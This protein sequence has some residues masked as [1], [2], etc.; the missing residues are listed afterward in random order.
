MTP[1]NIIASF[2]ATGI[3][4]VN[5]RAIVL[6]GEQK[7][8]S[9]PTA[10]LAKKKGIYFLPFYS[11]SSADDTPRFSKDELQLFEERFREGYD[12]T[13][14]ERYREKETRER[15]ESQRSG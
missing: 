7:P 3:Y 8:S 5:R 13:C 4:L 11:P 12:L 1:E 15:E 2:R 9:T 14:D 10:C 6:P